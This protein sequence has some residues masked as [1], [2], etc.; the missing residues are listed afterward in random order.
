MRCKRRDD[1]RRL[2]GLWD[3]MAALLLQ[4]CFVPSFENCPMLNSF[5]RRARQ[6]CPKLYL[7][8]SEFWTASGKHSKKPVQAVPERP[9]RALFFPLRP[10]HIIA[11]YGQSDPNSRRTYI[12]I[13]RP[14][15]RR[16]S[17]MRTEKLTCL[18]FK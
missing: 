1:Q 14:I 2:A 13:S 5:K 9:L 6:H 12:R 18:Y 4:T 10:H 15:P 11:A 3:R 7:A 8:L 16:R 17:R